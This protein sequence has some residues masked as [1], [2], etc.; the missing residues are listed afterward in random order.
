MALSFFIAAKDRENFLQQSE[1]PV[2]SPTPSF[3]KLVPPR[4][5]SLNNL[6][7]FDYLLGEGEGYFAVP[8]ST[9]IYLIKLSD[10]FLVVT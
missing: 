6:H 8:R 3:Q 4:V 5:G 2:K 10:K 9:R 1:I 7:K